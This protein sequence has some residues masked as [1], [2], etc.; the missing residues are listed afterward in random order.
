ME[1]DGQPRHKLAHLICDKAVKNT[2]WR[3]KKKTVSLTSR[4]EK[5]G[6]LQIKE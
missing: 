1:Q 5:T 3:N 6:Q 4:A 2:Q